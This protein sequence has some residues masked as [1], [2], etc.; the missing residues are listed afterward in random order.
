MRLF[1]TL[2]P[3]TSRRAAHSL[4]LKYV[5]AALVAGAVHDS[6]EAQVPSVWGYSSWGD[7]SYCPPSAPPAPPAPPPTPPLPPPLAPPPSSPPPP[8]PPPPPPP[9]PALPSDAGSL[10]QQDRALEVP[11]IAAIATALGLALL[12]LVCLLAARRKWARKRG[13]TGVQRMLPAVHAARSGEHAGVR[14]VVT[15]R[16]S[17]RAPRRLNAI[18]VT[19]LLPTWQHDV[20][21]AVHAARLRRELL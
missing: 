9:P 5:F 8:Q 18:G 6:F 7:Y 20:K 17:V 2:K 19:L 10:Q 1:T 13:R 21:S 14:F 4:L 15:V 12:L 16:V 3:Q 11:I